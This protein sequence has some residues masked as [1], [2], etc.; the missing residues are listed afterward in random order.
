MSDYNNTYEK[1][2][3]KFLIK[4]PLMKGFYNT[5]EGN[6]VVEPMQLRVDVG[7]GKASL[8]AP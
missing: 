8:A 6:A 3:R 7:S 5:L 1:E 2:F 4:P